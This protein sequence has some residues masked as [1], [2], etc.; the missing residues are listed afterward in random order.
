MCAAFFVVLGVSVWLACLS[1]SRAYCTA[2]FNQFTATTLALLWDGAPPLTL[3]LFGPSNLRNAIQ[4]IG[5]HMDRGCLGRVP[6]GG[7]GTG[8]GDPQA[9][10]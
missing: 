3:S 2:I 10:V 9:V 4:S 6:G 8:T 1:I 5:R 7:G